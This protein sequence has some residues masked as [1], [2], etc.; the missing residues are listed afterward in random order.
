MGGGILKYLYLAL[1]QCSILTKVAL[2]GYWLYFI[3]ALHTISS[4]Y[5]IILL[6]SSK[7]WHNGSSLSN[8]AQK[9]HLIHWMI[10]Y[11]KVHLFL[12]V[13]SFFSCL[14]SLVVKLKDVCFLLFKVETV[15]V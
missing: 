11:Q 7:A 8:G 14:L 3:F 13:V 2:G 4:N 9:N 12:G 5:K 1:V 15:A 10:C 6:A